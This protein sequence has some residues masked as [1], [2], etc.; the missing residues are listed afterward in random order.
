[1]KK[2]ILAL[3]LGLLLTGCASNVENNVDSDTDSTSTAVTQEDSEAD[4][5]EEKNNDSTS[6]PRMNPYTA[7]DNGY[8]ANF[9]VVKFG[10]YEQDGID[11]GT[12]AIEWY[13]VAR[14]D[15]KALLLSKYILKESK[16]DYEE[17]VEPFWENC[18]LRSWLNDDFYNSAFVKEE[19]DL[20]YETTLNNNDNPVWGTKGG[21]DTEDKVFILSIEEIAKYF[22]FSFENPYGEDV[23]GYAYAS[24]DLF[25]VPTNAA[26]KTLF[27]SDYYS[28]SNFEDYSEKY[29]F[30]N[31]LLI[32][33]GNPGFWV[34]N[35][36]GKEQWDIC[37]CQFGYICEEQHNFSGGDEGVR[38]AIWV[39]EAAL[40]MY[41]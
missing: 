1:M 28:N 29:G 21:N 40:T 3:M 17:I 25:S 5:N 9:D 37:Y 19:S 16:Y 36:G 13:V 22:T 23:Y 35:P 27:D 34:R 2:T 12:E 4:D 30:S 15:G 26:Y 31:D 32:G 24:E 38:P 18:L 33:L 10:S 39:D 8:C 20:I 11:N 41:Q 14:E 7:D 6:L